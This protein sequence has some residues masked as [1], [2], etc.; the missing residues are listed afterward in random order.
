MNIKNETKSNAESAGLYYHELLTSRDFFKKSFF[1]SIGLLALSVFILL[2]NLTRA[3]IVKGFA[4]LLSSDKQIMTV[5][6]IDELKTPV[7]EAQIKSDVT[8]Y[9]ETRESFHLSQ[10]DDLK[11]WLQYVNWH[12]TNQVYETF[13]HEQNDKTG[14]AT[15]VG[16]H[17]D[18]IA[19]V[20]AVSFQRD[21]DNKPV[22]ALVDFTVT[23]KTNDGQLL[24]AHYRATVSW[25][26]VGVPHDETIALNNWAGFEVTRYEVSSET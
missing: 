2:L 4:V 18:R 17:G 13:S 10:T 23:G 1:I 16:L 5:M 7:N 8:Q 3:P 26:Y 19:T 6:P 22:L 11:L 20:N 14:F 24:N 15:I 9:V 21:S 25:R 12:S